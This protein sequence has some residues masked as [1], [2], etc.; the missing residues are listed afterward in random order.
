M[1]DRHRPAAPHKKVP[2]P[3]TPLAIAKN[4]ITAIVAGVLTTLF[5][6][7]AI[8]V[9]HDA[10]T[11]SPALVAT[12]VYPRPQ[13]CGAPDGLTYTR[14][15]SSFKSRPL[16]GNHDGLVDEW[17]KNEGAVG[18]SGSTL[19][20]ALQGGSQN[21]VMITGVE[22]HVV[23]RMPPTRG[24]VISGGCGEQ[25]PVRYGIVDLS[26]QQPAIKYKF[27]RRTVS[28][29]TKADQPIKFPYAISSGD[30]GEYFAFI[31]NAK[32]CTCS[33]TAT[34]NWISRGKR[35][36]TPVDD[37]G[38]PFITSSTDNSAKKCTTG[39]GGVRWTCG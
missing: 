1:Y 17:P 14:D 33:W 30:K 6:A 18:L 28:G 20:I 24:T 21:Y 2:A 13:L 12:P 38:K 36:S 35:G 7:I 16:D 23:K 26:R 15:P 5:G 29:F 37:K 39:D 9:W 19:S 32:N 31:L 8:A 11:D 27:D 34:I 3:N 10:T 25:V 4:H 22:F